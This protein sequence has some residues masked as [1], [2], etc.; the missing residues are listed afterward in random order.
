MSAANMGS[1]PK[2]KQT[3]TRNSSV[4]PTVFVSTPKPVGGGYSV[5]FMTIKNGDVVLPITCEWSPRLPT[6]SDLRQ[7]VDMRLY[8][9][10][11]AYFTVAV[12]QQSSG[13]RAKK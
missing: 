11:L 4:K 10:E 9:V 3:S 12:W 6:E 8:D 2:S 5:Q 1:N 7:K 13:H